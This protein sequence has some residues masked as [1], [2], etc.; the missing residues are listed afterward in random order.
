[1]IE[2][3]FTIDYEIFG[4]GTG[5]LQELVHDPAEQL[6]ELFRKWDVRFV[7][8][9][10]AAELGKLATTR[11]DPAIAHVVSQLN[12]FHRD[13]FEIGLHLHPQWC[14]AQYVNGQW[15]LDYREY[16]LC[17]LDPQ[18][19]SEIVRESL[20]FL[21]SV[22][23]EP[24]FTPLSFRA[25]NWLFQP[26]AETARVLAANGIQ[27]D[28]SVFKGGLQRNH[29]LDYRAARHNG[30]FW[31]FSSDVNRPDKNGQLIEVP[32]QTE[33]V[34][35]WK[36]ASSKRLGSSNTFASAGSG[37]RRK[38]T[39][40]RD[41]ARFRYPK[42]LDFC[43]MM[44]DE[45]TGMMDKVIREDRS[46]PSQY[47]PI[48]SIGHTKDPIDFGVVESFLTF[49]RTNNIPVVTFNSVCEKLKPAGQSSRFQSVVNVSQG[50]Q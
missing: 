26:T 5:S 37:F 13:G 39:R 2:F 36:M 50:V 18:R 49:L 33:M 34:P 24:D 8:F 41:F 45:M 10:E 15:V 9:V 38:L 29:G 32:I 6:A 20:A 12:R 44:L 46:D 31:N 42:K 1:M 17:K 43:R 27:I 21:R 7:T 22:L 30:Y 23:G 48:V 14:N 35:S 3:L 4:N 16:N 28:S 19:I 25:G 40:I 47:R 11:V